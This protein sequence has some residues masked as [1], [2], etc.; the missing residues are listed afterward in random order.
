MNRLLG[1]GLALYLT[2]TASAVNWLN[3]NANNLWEDDANWSGGAQPTATDLVIIGLTGANKAI[4]SQAGELGQDVLIG[5]GTAGEM[6]MTGG[7]LT[8]RKLLVGDGVSGVFDQ[9]SGAITLTEDVLVGTSGGS[10]EWNLAGGTVVARKVLAG[11][12]NETTTGTIN[13]S[14]GTVTTVENYLT[15]DNG[16]ATLNMTGGTIHVGL[17]DER[18]LVLGLSGALGSS[19]TTIAGTAQVFANDAIVGDNARGANTLVVEGTGKLNAGRQGA[20]FRIGANNNVTGNVTVQG[21]G[22]INVGADP[23]NGVR[24]PIVVGVNPSAASVDSATLLVK[25]N[26]IVRAGL[27]I[28]AD[29]NNAKGKVTLESGTIDIT[30]GFVVGSSGKVGTIAELNISGGLLKAQ[31]LLV[32]DGANQTGTANITGGS[33]ELTGSVLVGVD[34]NLGSAL[35]TIDA[36]GTVLTANNFHLRNNGD[37]IH[38][39]GDIVLQGSLIITPDAGPGF[40]QGTYDLQMGSISMGGDQTGALQAHIGSGLL[41]SSTPLSKLQLAFDGSRTLLSVSQIPEPATLTLLV[42]AL[43]GLYGMG[44][45]ANKR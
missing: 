3:T 32:N 34:S 7:S 2:T 27:L 8:A 44:R 19:S 14:G 43:C 45:R 23:L 42:V 21:S 33:I 22:E 12:S 9:D 39:M 40:G 5:N 38:R 28:M 24:G 37:V 25:D 41:F 30:G 29:T 1:L 26:G 20:A 16:I 15:G 36:P 18:A 4:L 35:M 11:L 13:Q 17:A 31:V 10:G 6:Q